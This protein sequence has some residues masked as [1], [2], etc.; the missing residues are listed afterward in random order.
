M[1]RPACL[2]IAMVVLF[3]FGSLPPPQFAGGQSPVIVKLATL[4]PEGSPWIQVLKAAADEA[5]QKTG[6]AVQFKIYPGGV[7]GDERD[8]VRKMHIGQLQAAMLSSA[9]LASMFS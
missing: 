6:N 4:A 3:L 1:R 7:M 5:Q 8:M 9:S 2:F